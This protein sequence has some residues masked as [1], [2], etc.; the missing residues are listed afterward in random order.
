M[1]PG[2]QGRPR[3]GAHPSRRIGTLG[4]VLLARR[5]GVVV[6]SGGVVAWR[7]AVVVWRGGS[8]GGSNTAVLPLIRSKVAKDLFP[9]R[10]VPGEIP[11][12]VVLSGADGLDDRVEQ[13]RALSLLVRHGGTVGGSSREHRLG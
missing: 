4:V 3:S 8:I 10:P 13:V 11:G 1:W 6:W 2:S 7:G 5:S 9:Q 12:D